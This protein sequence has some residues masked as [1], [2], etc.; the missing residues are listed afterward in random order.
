[1]MGVGF[2]RGRGDG[3]HLKICLRPPKH[4]IVSSIHS[5]N[6]TLIFRWNVRAIFPLHAHTV[7]RVT[8]NDR[9]QGGRVRVWIN[10]QRI[11]LESGGLTIVR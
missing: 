5:N 6:T 1:M 8:R 11:Y 10:Y 7:L 9:R 3:V 2:A 4:M